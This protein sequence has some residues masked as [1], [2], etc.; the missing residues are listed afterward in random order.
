MQINPR[1]L[2]PS[3]SLLLA[4]DAS[5]RHLSFTRAAQDLFLTQSAVSRQVQAL[6]AL[7]GVALFVRDQRK[8][9]L[10]GAGAAY[11][12]E[13]SGAL[14]RIRNG[15]L[16]AIASC[17]GSGALHLAV[18]PTFASKW[19]LPRLSDFYRQHPGVLVHLHARIGQFDLDAAGM[20]AAIGV[21]DGSWPGLVA[22]RLMDEMLLPVISPSLRREHALHTPADLARHLLLV[23]ATRSSAWL[24]WFEQQGLPSG[25][26]RMGPQ[27][28]LT[29]HLIQAVVAGIGVGLL[30]HFMVQDELASGSLEL[31]FDLP[32]V[33]GYSYYLFVRPEKRQL[34]AVASFSDWLTG[35][36][37]DGP[38]PGPP[39]LSFS[40]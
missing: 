21:G 2:T 23:V 4:F 30:P 33:S 40:R 39:A 37:G 13:V 36:L 24:R 27:F 12:R 15:S 8:I 14:Q 3:M 17:A 11:H 34:P 16:Q 5:A 35:Q 38:S 9:T 28:E 20:D 22:H 1:K 29:S 32:L 25:A 26:L 31:A 18:L 19:L 7:L 10:T 6:E